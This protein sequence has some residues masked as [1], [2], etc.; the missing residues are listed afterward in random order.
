MYA[1]P[2][3]YGRRTLA[4][5][6]FSEHSPGQWFGLNYRDGK[7]MLRMAFDSTSSTARPASDALRTSA[8]PEGSP[9]LLP[10]FIR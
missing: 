3:V 8:V 2:W 9:I 7:A 1:Q 4:S 5:A 6:V 10:Q